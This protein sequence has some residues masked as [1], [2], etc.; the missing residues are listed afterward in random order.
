MTRLSILSIGIVAAIC[1]ASDAEARGG[2]GGRGGGK[3]GGSHAVKGYTT[4]NGVY[5]APHRAT[6]PNSTKL[7]N[8]STKGN[9]NPYTG[10][11]GTVDPYVPKR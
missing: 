3:T 7:D 4:K 10:K 5:V 1:V 9:V 11:P 6:N 2:G 8:W